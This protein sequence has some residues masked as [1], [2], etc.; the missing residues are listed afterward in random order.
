MINGLVI[1][2]FNP[3]HNGHLELIY[4]AAQQCDIVFVVLCE[5]PTDV[6][7]GATRMTWIQGTFEQYIRE[8]LDDFPHNPILIPKITLDNLPEA[9]EPWAKRISEIIPEI[10]FQYL[11]T[12]E[13]WGNDFADLLN[14][15]PTHV[16]V[17]RDKHL[18]SATEIKDNPKANFNHLC[19]SAQRQLN[20]HIAIV[21]AESSGK[22]TLA[23]ALAEHYETV[24]APE[25]GRY[26]TDGITYPLHELTLDDFHFIYEQQITAARRFNT[27]ARNGVLISDTEAIVTQAWYRRYTG[28]EIKFP[29]EYPVD[30]YIFCD[31]DFN[32]TQDGTRESENY[33]D[34]MYGNIMIDVLTQQKCDIL[35]VFGD[36]KDRMRESVNC[37]DRIF[38]RKV[39][40]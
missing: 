9:N 10:S 25:Y 4:Q 28:E 26:Y 16:Y 29:Y 33:Q 34:V 8:H 38:D 13:D 31:H 19:K 37:I 23:K 3:P 40:F 12:S 35:C 22:T 30:L 2:K 11:F 24:W 18:I 1:G 15:N 7:N 14:G 20:I 21:G 39:K 32:W 36:H 5:K 6:Y 17:G 27:I